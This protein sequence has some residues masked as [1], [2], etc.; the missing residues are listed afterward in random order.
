MIKKLQWILSTVYT[1]ISRA[2]LT[3]LYLE[4][5]PILLDLSIFFRDFLLIGLLISTPP[6]P[7][8]RYLEP[9]CVS[10]GRSK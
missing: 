5:K 6:L 8:A 4:L 2:R 10:L 9:F 1:C 7:P 3:P